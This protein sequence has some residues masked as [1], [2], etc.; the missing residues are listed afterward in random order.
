MFIPADSV[1]AQK[2]IKEYMKQNL[3]IEEINIL[4]DAAKEAKRRVDEQLK[5]MK[6]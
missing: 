2:A 5:Q 3:T 6:I 1:K 4:I